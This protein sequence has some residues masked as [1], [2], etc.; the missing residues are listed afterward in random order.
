MF[1]IRFF[2]LRLSIPKFFAP[3][4]ASCANRLRRE[5]REIFLQRRGNSARIIYSLGD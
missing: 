3:A 4:A 1:I 5:F 2:V